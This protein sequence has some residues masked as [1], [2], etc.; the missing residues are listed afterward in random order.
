MAPKGNNMLPN[1]HFHKHWQRRVKTWFDQP[2]RKQR[3]RN[4][5]IAK[6]KAVA[7]RPVAGLLRAI[8]RCPSNRYN[9][10]VRLGRGFTLEELKAAGIGKNEA[11]SIGIAVDHRRTNRSVESL[12][13][14]AQRLKEYKSRLILFP[15]R[16]SKP[17]K[18]DSS[19]E[20]LKMATQLRGA[21]LPIKKQV[22]REKA[23]AVTDELKNFEVY[24]HLRRI[25]ADTR[26]VGK[27]EKKAKEATEEGLGKVR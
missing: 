6:A 10:K 17:K 12:Q 19:A 1:A 23:R 21:V 24:R 9:K 22:R 7:P 25:R 20:D 5:R 2:A 8:V 26:L 4:A 27:R 14:N 3:R 13:L 15:R 18:G 11:K 16:L